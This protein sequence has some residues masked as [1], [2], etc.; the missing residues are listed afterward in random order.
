MKLQIG[1]FLDNSLVNGEG[2]R[3]VI[4]VSG[5]FHNCESCHN[6]VMQ[7]FYY[8]D[9]VSIQNILLKIVK[10][11]PIISG[12]TFSGGEPFES[13]LALSKLSEGIRE[14]GLGI[15]C[16]S[17]YTFEE[18]IH[19]GDRDKLRLFKLIDVLIDGKFHEELQV[20][21]SKYTGS[22]NQRIIDIQK[23]ILKNQVVLWNK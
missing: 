8:G 1:G 21:A 12:V 15:W 7:S 4:F 22:S 2:M 6:Q 11:I 20:G 9:C 13:A 3:S 16:Y 10:N 18:I 14:Q 19:S 23:S 17:G 5:C